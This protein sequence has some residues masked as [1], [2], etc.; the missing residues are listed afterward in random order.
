MRREIA[1]QFNSAAVFGP[2][3]RQ[4]CKC[5]GGASTAGRPQAVA[6][7]AAR[8]RAQHR[9]ILR[10]YGLKVGEVSRGRFEARNPDLIEG[11]DMLATVIGAMLQAR[12]VLWNEFIQLHRAMLKIV[13]A[14]LS[15]SG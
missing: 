4:V 15:A 7:Q 10:G 6:G 3:A 11:H 1:D 12:A 5:S 2:C 14:D 8:R 13:R 9:G